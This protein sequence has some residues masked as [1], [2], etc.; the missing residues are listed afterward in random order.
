MLDYSTGRPAQG[1]E[2]QEQQQLQR[3]EQ[4]RNG[5]NKG[6]GRGCG[7]GRGGE[8]AARQARGAVAGTRATPVTSLT[9]TGPNADSSSP[10]IGLGLGLRR[11][12]TVCGRRTVAYISVLTSIFSG[13][14]T[15]SSYLLAYSLFTHLLLLYCLPVL[16]THHTPGRR[17]RTYGRLVARARREGKERKKNLMRLLIVH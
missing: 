1:K 5:H 2:E 17:N 10:A 4:G 8:G 9:K 7:A 15:N 16:V 13:R 14:S 6:G 3:Q 12:R 11:Q